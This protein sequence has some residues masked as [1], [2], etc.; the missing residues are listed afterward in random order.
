MIQ[1]ISK[2]FGIFIFGFVVL[3]GGLVLLPEIAGMPQVDPGEIIGVLLAFVVIAGGFTWYYFGSSTPE[4][5]RRRDPDRD[6]D[7]IR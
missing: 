6:R 7:S 5:R 2:Y 4:P 1:L 3:V